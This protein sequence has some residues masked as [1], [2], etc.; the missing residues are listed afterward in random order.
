MVGIS[1]ILLANKLMGA[2]M[3]PVYAQH[4]VANRG[5]NAISSEAP[6]SRYNPKTSQQI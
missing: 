4:P 1:K 2:S 5:F 6:V 3:T